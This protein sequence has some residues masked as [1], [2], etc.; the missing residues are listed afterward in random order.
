MNLDYVAV[1]PNA[2]ADLM[3]KQGVSNQSEWLYGGTMA[4]A[5]AFGAECMHQQVAK[6]ATAVGVPVIV[7]INH[8]NMRAGANSYS[9]PLGYVWYSHVQRMDHAGELHRERSAQS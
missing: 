4:A 6:S 3:K 5:N 1:D 7:S 9:G 2:G 8:S